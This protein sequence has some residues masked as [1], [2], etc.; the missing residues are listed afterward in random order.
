LAIDP[1]IEATVIFASLYSLMSVGLTLTYM[2]TKVPNFAHGTFITLGLYMGFTAF[3]FWGMNPYAAAPLSFLL[4]G[5]VAVAMYLLVLKPLAARGV[6][7]V[8]LMIATLAV[9]TLFLGVVNVYAGILSNVYSV[10]NSV[11]IILFTADFSI[12]GIRGLFIAGPS[13]LAAFVIGLY[14]LLTRTKFGMAMRAAVENPNLAGTLGINVGRVYLTSWFLAGGLGG[15]AGSFLPMIAAGSPSTGSQLIVAI[16]AGSIVGG[17]GSVFGAVVGGSV[18]GIAGGLLPTEL[19]NVVGPW[20]VEYSTIMPVAV[21]VVSLL[22]VPKGLTG[23]NWR[24][25][26]RREAKVERVRV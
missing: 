11:T 14:L 5:S 26:F 18:V 25:L 22:V 2:T 23:V 3:H 4:S 9:D 15:I 16:F 19:A 8:G 7:L 13:F 1:V 6:P 12:D 21:M 10:G 17:L 24:H 20:I